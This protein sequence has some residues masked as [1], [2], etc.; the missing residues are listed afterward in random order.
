MHHV[1]ERALYRV[2]RAWRVRGV[3]ITRW[4]SA[5]ARACRVYAHAA[6]L[7]PLPRC[8]R[9]RV[10]TTRIFLCARV[11]VARARA[12]FSRRA[13]RVMPWRRGVISVSYREKR[14]FFL[15]CAAVFGSCDICVSAAAAARLRSALLYKAAHAA[16]RC[17]LAAPGAHV[18]C[19]LVRNCSHLLLLRAC[20]CVYCCRWRGARRQT[21][22]RGALRWAACAC[23]WPLRA[24]FARRR[25]VLAARACIWQQHRGARRALRAR[26]PHLR[27]KRRRAGL[28]AY[29]VLRAPWRHYT[30]AHAH[31]W[32]GAAC[33]RAPHMAQ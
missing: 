19:L 13:A 26:F 21:R 18:F 20:V 6:C 11:R 9:T 25:G 14:G 32:R 30:D 28:L 17:G 24:A 10:K 2:L 5:R 8:A 7:S 22:Q 33:A 12:R 31:A 27:R 1:R 3:R 15:H 4:R 16:L 29:G 23:A